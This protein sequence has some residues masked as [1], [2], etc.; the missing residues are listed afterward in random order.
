M[1]S[2]SASAPLDACG[3]IVVDDGVNHL[4]H[5]DD[6]FHCSARRRRRKSFWWPQAANADSS[7]INFLLDID[8]KALQRF[9]QQ[10][11]TTS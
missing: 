8:R 4:S 9:K 3:R 11:W 7:I 2:I 1:P 10:S 5:G 6:E